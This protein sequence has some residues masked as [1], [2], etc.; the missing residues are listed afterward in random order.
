[1][2]LIKIPLL[3]C[4]LIV[5]AIYLVWQL[6]LATV[7]GVGLTTDSVTYA[8]GAKSILQL[9]SFENLGSHYPPLYILLV[10]GL[11]S[12]KGDV[13]GAMKLV[14]IGFIVL[15]F[16]LFNLIIY[17]CSKKNLSVTLI[18]TMVFIT[19]MPIFFIHSMAW[20]EAAFSFFALVGL[21]FV[22]KYVTQLSDSVGWLVLSAVAVGMAFLTRY[23][24][25]ALVITFLL[26]LVVFG[27]KNISKLILDLILFVGISCF[28]MA[29][30]VGYNLMGRGNGTDR[31]IVF[32]PITKA[33]LIYGIEVIKHWYFLD[34]FPGIVLAIFLII[35]AGLFF[36]LLKR[37][38]KAYE[39]S[40]GMLQ[41][42]AMFIIIYIA[43]LLFSI[44]FFDAQTPLDDRILYPVYLV[45][46]LCLI[47]LANQYFSM[48]GN[49]RY[50]GIGLFIFLIILSIFQ[51]TRRSSFIRQSNLNGIGFASR[52]W[53]ESDVLHWLNSSS[54]PKVIYTNGPD[55]LSLY[56]DVNSQMIP[57]LMSP[58]DRI[59][60]KNFGNELNKMVEEMEGNRGLIV[61]FNTIKWRWYLPTIQQL[62]AN[63]PL[64]IIYQGK[65]GVVEKL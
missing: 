48:T 14:Q 19:S 12:L 5:F 65:D 40:T 38:N 32:H 64:Q 2:K 45:S 7:W 36:Y 61:Y 56:T 3:S 23:V 21:Y 8:N 16:I 37:E 54:L 20:S 47:L 41:V 31:N 46:V 63:L 51:E 59:P 27:K 57:A 13:L 33:K 52:V 22:A 53:V 24:G 11:A 18:G 17:D 1:M 26:W 6:Y 62:N 43:F 42:G 34:A 10:S 35:L 9:G 50:I 15:N 30:W 39:T 58:N 60:N 25:L 4:L 29:L 55:V 44:S 28:S 49:R